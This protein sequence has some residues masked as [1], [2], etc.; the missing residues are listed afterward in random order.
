MSGHTGS[1]SKDFDADGEDFQALG[2]AFLQLKTRDEF[3][4]FMLDICTHEEM[5]NLTNRWKVAR[6]LDGP[7]PP[8]YR[9]I[10]DQTGVSVTT[11]GRVSRFLNEEPHQGYRLVL[12]RLKG[13]TQGD[14]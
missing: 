3:K 5:Q 4:R 14:S 8:S 2:D 12:N 1:R 10:H 9:D 11:V 6:I 7:S 13:Y